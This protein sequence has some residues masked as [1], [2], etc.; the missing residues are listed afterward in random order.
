[1]LTK[2]SQWAPIQFSP[3]LHRFLSESRDIRCNIKPRRCSFFDISFRTL[4]YFITS[5]Q[6]LLSKITKYWDSFVSHCN[7]KVSQK[8]REPIY[9]IAIPVSEARRDCLHGAEE[10]TAALLEKAGL[11]G[12]KILFLF[13]CLG[14][15]IKELPAFATSNSVVKYK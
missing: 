2:L 4:D 9:K 10:S 3:L 5:H 8:E 6:A 15:D 12:A 1:M 11:A 13:I 14:V 7:T